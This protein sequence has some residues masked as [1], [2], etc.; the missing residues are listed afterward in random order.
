MIYVDKNSVI[1]IEGIIF[2]WYKLLGIYEYIM[3]VY[4]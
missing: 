1:I 3:L 2:W 4:V